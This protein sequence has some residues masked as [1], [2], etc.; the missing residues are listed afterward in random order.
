MTVVVFIY[1]YV[2]DISELKGSPLHKPFCFPG[3]PYL[4]GLMFINT[5]IMRWQNNNKL[6]LN[7]FVTIYFLLVHSFKIDTAQ[8]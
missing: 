1:C 2:S 4:V 8:N 5:F 3:P 7:N 6:K